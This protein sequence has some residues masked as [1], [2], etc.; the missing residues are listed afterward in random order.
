MANIEIVKM[1]IDTEI[2]SIIEKIKSNNTWDIISDDEMASV[3]VLIGGLAGAM[4]EIY[5]K[6]HPEFENPDEQF[7]KLVEKK[8]LEKF[9]S[10]ETNFIDA[11]ES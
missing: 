10:L 2:T 5:Q 9:G 11:E 8:A 1:F 7:E 4:L 3:G 6:R